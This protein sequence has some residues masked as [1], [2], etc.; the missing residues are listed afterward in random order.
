M[1]MNIL[2]VI[3]PRLASYLIETYGFD[4]VYFT[5][6]GCY[7]LS[8]FFILFIRGTGLVTSA[9]P[10]P[11]SITLDKSNI[12]GEI[13]KGFQY[14]RRE[15]MILIILAFSLAVTVLSQPYQQLLPIFVED[16]LKVGTKGGGELMMIAGAGAL[17]GSITITFLPNKKRGLML[18]GS[19]LIAGM[20][21]I[22][23]SFSTIWELTMGTMVFIG[24]AQTFRMTISSTLLQAYSQPEYRGRVMSIFSMQWGLMS[25]FTF[26]AGVLSEVVPVQWVLGSLVMLLVALAILSLMF[27]PSIRRLD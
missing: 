26:L 22:S 10:V 23:F 4:V 7:V 14:I 13:Q 24:L 3:G 12:L 25:I 18:L 20:A 15:S 1:G 21:L 6:A 27:I 2:F 16:I 19:G 5:M 17:A 9:P 8:A 11:N